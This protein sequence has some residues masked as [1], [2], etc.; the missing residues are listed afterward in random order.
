MSTSSDE[1]MQ[2]LDLEPSDPKPSAAKYEHGDHRL[3][4]K[5]CRCDE[6]REGIRLHRR[7]ERAKWRSDPSR[8]DRTGHGKLTTY[9]NHGCRCVD[10]KAANTEDTRKRWTER[11][12]RAA[13]AGSD[14]WSVSVRDMGGFN[15]RWKP[16][17]DGCHIWQGNRGGN[18]YGQFY[19]GGK[20][21][22]AHRW[23]FL[24]AHGYLPP[25]VC[26]ACD[27]PLCVREQCLFPGTAADNNADMISKGRHAF[28]ERNGS[29]KLSAS[30]VQ[31]LLD[32][33]R[34][35][36]VT[37]HALAREFGISRTHV[38]SIVRGEKRCA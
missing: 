24:Q 36:G 7:E 15:A 9:K 2:S 32:R 33:H 10:C 22:L 14:G 34:Q 12:E 20:Q 35:G 6:C 8:A 38:G 28:G 37:Q 31:A 19:V 3:Y 1:V 5:G 16:D 11:R 29:T 30:E 18:G 25:F 17:A 13:L 27:K 4:V 21:R 23:L 26:H